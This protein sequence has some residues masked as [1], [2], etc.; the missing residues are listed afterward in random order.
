LVAVGLV[1]SVR[2]GRYLLGP[3]IVHYDRQLR[4]ADPLIQIAQPILWRMAGE[5]EPPGILFIARV[6]R[7]HLMSMIEQRLGF[8]AFETSYDRGRFMPLYR[9]APP[10]AILAHT[11]I[12]NL[13]AGF[14]EAHAASADPLE[15][16]RQFRRQLRDTRRRGCAIESGG[17]DTHAT[18]ISVPLLQQDGG[19]A[20]SLNL[21]L[22]RRSSTSV[23]AIVPK[24]QKAA[25]R[26]GKRLESVVGSTEARSR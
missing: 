5:L 10:L 24:L 25:S 16:W 26:I 8:T 12:R 23:D 22:P 19:V 4:L 15:E 14:I 9:G 17:V 18:Y 20:G 2:P 3:G 7:S 11:A 6:Y 1:F 21:G 13:R